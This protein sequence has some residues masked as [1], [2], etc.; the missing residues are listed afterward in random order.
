MDLAAIGT[1]VFFSVCNNW[2]YNATPS[3]LLHYI[4]FEIWVVKYRWSI[5]IIKGQYRDHLFGQLT[6][7][8][9]DPIW[10]SDMEKYCQNIEKLKRFLFCFSLCER[11]GIWHSESAR[12]VSTCP[13]SRMLIILGEKIGLRNY[14]A[15]ISHLCS[16]S[17]A[18]CFLILEKYTFVIWIMLF[19][20]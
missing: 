7:Q 17:I 19:N 13:L 1:N 11:S 2:F 20:F 18:Q 16:M 14:F 12:P 15:I 5:Q 4:S 8:P 10:I 6:N 9:L 3:T